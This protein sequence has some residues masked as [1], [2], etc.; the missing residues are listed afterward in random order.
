MAQPT[1][2]PITE[3]DQVRSARRLSVPRAWVANRPADLPGP[4]RPAGVRFGTPGP[5]QGFALRLARRFE[6]RL[7][8]TAEES[9]EDAVVGAAILA[10]KRAG[11]VGRAPCV[12]DL[13]AALALFGFLMA[14]PPAGLVA[15]RRRLFA[16]VSRDYVAQRALVD[17]VPDETLLLGASE[18]TE[19]LGSWWGLLHGEPAAVE[20]AGGRPS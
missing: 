8:L 2:V 20:P 16:S 6:D 14:S 15:E 7:R 5:D 4:K 13:H 9:V 3:A 1:F 19:R 12:Y 10:S 11:L 17:A 18:L